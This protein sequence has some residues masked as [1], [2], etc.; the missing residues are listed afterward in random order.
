M[1][2]M[3][4]GVEAGCAHVDCTVLVTQEN[5]MGELVFEEVYG[6]ANGVKEG[7]T[8]GYEGGVVWFL[9]WQKGMMGWLVVQR[10]APCGPIVALPNSWAGDVGPF[11]ELVFAWH[12]QT[13]VTSNGS[14]H[15]PGR[16]SLHMHRHQESPTI[17]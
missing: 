15:S 1:D 10:V 13:R 8:G 9:V 14:S 5:M 6:R 4:E 2:H 16:A 12:G 3:A 11:S 7:G 17:T